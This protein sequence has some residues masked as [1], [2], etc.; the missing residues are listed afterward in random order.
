MEVGSPPPPS[1]KHQ[2]MVNKVVNGRTTHATVL[3]MDIPSP[4][5][6]KESY[7]R[8]LNPGFVPQLTTRARYRL[9]LKRKKRL[10]RIKCSKDVDSRYITAIR[11]QTVSQVSGTSPTLVFRFNLFKLGQLRPK[12]F[13]GEVCHVNNRD[14]K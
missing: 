8:N 13:R 2:Q 6:S 5:A 1:R 11:S 4:L 12:K 7:R 10:N 3:G 9:S 14:V